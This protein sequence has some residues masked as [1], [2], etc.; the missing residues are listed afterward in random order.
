MARGSGAGTGVIVALVVSVVCNVGLL[1]IT[2]MMYTGKAEALVATDVAAR[3]IDVD[4]VTHV[5]NYEMPI[6]PE[7]YVH[8][9]GRT[10][11]AGASG[12][13]ISLC[14]RPEIELLRAIERRTDARP[15][16]ETDHDDLTYTMPADEGRGAA[17]AAKAARAAAAEARSRQPKRYHPRE[18]GYGSIL[19]PAAST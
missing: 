15:I 11:R 10:A 9:I 16:L 18:T 13:A 19:L 6:E 2:F 12:R 3:G 17:K 5:V 1:T 14:D 4:G 8:R 7:S